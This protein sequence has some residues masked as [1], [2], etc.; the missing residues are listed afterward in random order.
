M[1][2]AECLCV[3]AA[4]ASVSTDASKPRFSSTSESGKSRA[5]KAG[6]GDRKDDEPAWQRGGRGCR[7]GSDLTK[8]LAAKPTKSAVSTGRTI[9]RQMQAP[10]PT[11]THVAKG[12]VKNSSEGRVPFVHET[13]SY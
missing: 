13:R 1:S 10:D 5:S 12:R 8:P 4:R 9:R 6:P 7:L 2:A 11:L 3:A